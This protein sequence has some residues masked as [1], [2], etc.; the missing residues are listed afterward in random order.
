MSLHYHVI[1][2][3]VIAHV[4]SLRLLKKE[5]LE[6]IASQL[7]L[8]NSLDLNPVDY[9]MSGILREKVI[10]HSSLIWTN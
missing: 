4:L 1:L 7:Q 2:K 8:P 10:K 3:M 9:S 6:F 5:T